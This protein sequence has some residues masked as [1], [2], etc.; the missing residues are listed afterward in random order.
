MRNEPH[1][2]GKA[3]TFSNVRNNPLIFAGCTV[4]RP[5]AKPAGT[6]GST[7]QDGAPP[8]EAMEQNG[9]LLIRDLW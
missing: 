6:S 4:K 9:D 8:P 1:L 2:A 7:D 5:K 3:F